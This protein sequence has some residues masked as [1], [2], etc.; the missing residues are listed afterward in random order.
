MMNDEL[1]DEF[2]DCTIFNIGDNQIKIE[3]SRKGKDVHLESIAEETNL[4]T[5]SQG[6]LQVCLRNRFTCHV[7]PIK[8]RTGTGEY[9]YETIGMEGLT[10]ISVTLKLR[11]PGYHMFHPFQNPRWPYMTWAKTLRCL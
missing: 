2:G 4:I 7:I 3:R 5:G 1:N 9:I 8:R 6:V 11:Q 10:S